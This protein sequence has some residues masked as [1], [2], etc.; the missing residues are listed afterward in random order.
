LATFLR[1]ATVL[2]GAGCISIWSSLERSASRALICASVSAARPDIGKRPIAT[3]PKA[4]RKRE[5]CM[6]LINEISR[7]KQ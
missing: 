7:V 4:A 5:I 6:T 1:V 2:V 3:T